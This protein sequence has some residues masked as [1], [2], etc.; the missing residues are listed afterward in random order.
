M[1]KQ[2]KPATALINETSLP[3][4]GTPSQRGFFLIGGIGASAGG[5]E[6][7]EQFLRQVPEGSG[8]ADGI[9]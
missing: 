6:A 7:L 8:L 2:T 4:Q 3:P 9:N 5:L 1:K